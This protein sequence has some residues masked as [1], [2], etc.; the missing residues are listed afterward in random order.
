MNGG[1]YDEGYVPLGLQIENGVYGAGLLQ[2][3]NFLFVRGGFMSRIEM[4]SV[5]SLNCGL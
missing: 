5:W 1:I 4:A 2:V 3:K